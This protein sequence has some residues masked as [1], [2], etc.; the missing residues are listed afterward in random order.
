[1]DKKPLLELFKKNKITILISALILS[2]ILGI[3][4]YLS[5]QSPLT[6]RIQPFDIAMQAYDAYRFQRYKEAVDC[7][8]QA[9][10]AKPNSAEIW[11]DL[12]NAYFQQNQFNQACTAYKKALQLNPGDEDTLVNLRL[13]Q[14]RGKGGINKKKT[15]LLREKLPP[16]PDA[17]SKGF[18]K[19]FLSNLNDCLRQ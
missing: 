10:M 4:T 18:W 1:M 8:E 13:A 9:S 7:F 2:V 15:S 11:Y 14:E 3:G 19:N 12:G 6:N 16:V 5:S 17:K